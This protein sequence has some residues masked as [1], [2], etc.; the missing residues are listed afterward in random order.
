M[1]KYLVKVTEFLTMKYV[2]EAENEGEAYEK[3]ADAYQDGNITL[4]YDD[5]NGYEV[6]VMREATTSDT[7]YYDILEVSE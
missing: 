1:K 4:D 5:Y 2:V 3:A 7:K 6:E